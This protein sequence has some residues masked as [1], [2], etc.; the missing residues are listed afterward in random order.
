MFIYISVV[1]VYVCV[2]MC[3]CVCAYVRACVRASARARVGHSHQHCIGSVGV[4]GQNNHTGQSP[5]H[6]L[7]AL[8]RHFWKHRMD[9]LVLPL[10]AMC[11][12]V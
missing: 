6:N 9:S 4:L 2:C 11:V 7:H 12:C 3:V 5:K 8:T 10:K 1:C